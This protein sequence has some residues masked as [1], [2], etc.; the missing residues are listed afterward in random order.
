MARLRVIVGRIGTGDVAGEFS[1]EDLLEIRAMCEGPLRG[2]EWVVAMV[3]V[4]DLKMVVDG[5]L[6][7]MEGD[8]ECLRCGSRWKPRRRGRPVQCPRCK[9]LKWEEP[10][11]E[12]QAM[13]V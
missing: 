2:A 6:A 1:R 12:L 9:S 5:A 13:L 7:M 4:G 10:D 11:A 8:L 3:S